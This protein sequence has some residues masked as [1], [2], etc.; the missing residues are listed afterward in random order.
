MNR[1][2]IA[3]VLRRAAIE[4]DGLARDLRA[5]DADIGQLLAQ[6][7]PEYDS[8]IHAA[9]LIRQTASGLASFLRDLAATTGKDGACDAVSAVQNLTMRAQAARLSGTARPAMPA[10]SECDLWLD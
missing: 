8:D 10:K 2:D 9:D 1:E 5:L 3:P 4:A 6:L 7:G